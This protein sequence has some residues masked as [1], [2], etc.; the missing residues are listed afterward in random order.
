VLNLIFVFIL[1]KADFVAP[2]MALAVASTTTAW[3]QVIL[4]YLRLHQ[5]TIYR[6]PAALIRYG[7]KLLIPLALMAAVIVLLNPGDWSSLQATERAMWLVGI[8]I[9]AKVTYVA[10]LL[11]VGVRPADFDSSTPI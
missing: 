8:I 11:L 5:D 6:L 2:H 1:V 10:G 4:L 7:L 9:A 3:Q